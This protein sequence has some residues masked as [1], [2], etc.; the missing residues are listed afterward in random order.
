MNV[1]STNHFQI[2]VW[3]A[4]NTH[5]QEMLPQIQRNKLSNVYFWGSWFLKR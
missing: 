2:E 1:Y 4:K 3:T 5:K